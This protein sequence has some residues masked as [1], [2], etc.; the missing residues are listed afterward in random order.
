[1]TG[2]SKR[3]FFPFCF[4]TLRV[5]KWDLGSIAEEVGLGH[6]HQ[7]CSQMRGELLHKS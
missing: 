1:M 2:H 5:L 6:S 7:N 3:D 4:H